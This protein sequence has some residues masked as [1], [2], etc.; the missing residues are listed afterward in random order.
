MDCRFCHQPLEHVFLSLGS[1]PLSNSYLT[2]EQLH[3]REIF[4]PLEVYV[5]QTCFL[6]QLQE[7]ETP[8]AI[9]GDYA[10]FSSYSESWLKHSKDYVDKMTRLFGI[11]TRSYVIEI[12]SN[13][14]YLLQYF[15]EKGIPVLGIEPALNVAKV[16]N[17]K[18]IPTETIFFGTETAKRIAAG[19]RCADLLLGNNVLAHVPNLNDFVKG[20]KILLKPKG[21][22]TMEFPHLLR[23]MEETQFDTIYHEHFSYFSFITVE[24]L[25]KAHGLTIFDVEELATHGGSLRIYARHTEEKTK[26]TAERVRQLKQKE[27]EAGY[28]DIRHYLGFQEKVTEMK[29]DILKFLIQ[30]KEEGKSIVGYGAPAKGNTLLNYCGIRTDFIDYTVDRNPHKQGF[31]LPGSHIPIA[32]P[33]KIRETKPNYVFILP[34]NLKDEIIEQMAFIREWGGKFVI[35]IPRIQV[36]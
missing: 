25:F 35:P 23:L 31:Y 15:V 29:K 5:C 16:A 3:Q 22:I 24:R 9:F 14:G 13:D 12:A 7:Y 28:G 2:K 11:D 33:S 10:Y 8:E 30:A 26:P 1:F 18:G 17:K 27:M 34:W 19:G 6:V 20:L 36:M 4:Y 21:I 32:A